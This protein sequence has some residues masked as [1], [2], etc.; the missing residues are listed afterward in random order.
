V[1]HAVE[2]VR[3]P[4][5]LPHLLRAGWRVHSLTDAATLLEGVAVVLPAGA[6]LEAVPPSQPARPAWRQ[7]RRPP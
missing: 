5:D 1:Q 2:R 4:D 3:D 7:S 6:P